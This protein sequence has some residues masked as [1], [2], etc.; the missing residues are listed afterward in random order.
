MLQYGGKTRLVVVDR[1]VELPNEQGF[2][3]DELLRVDDEKNMITRAVQVKRRYRRA[4]D[5]E[6]NRIVEGIEL[7]KTFRVL[8]GIAGTEFPTSTVK[9]QLRLTR[10]G[11]GQL[12]TGPTTIV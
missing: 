3:F 9:S 10:P 4:F 5:N 8:D 7:I 12:E 2:G 1:T 6:G 11:P